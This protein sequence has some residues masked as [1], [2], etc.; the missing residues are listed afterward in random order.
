MTTPDPR[1][2]LAGRLRQA[3]TAEDA[4]HAVEII[5]GAGWRPDGPL[6]PLTAE[7]ETTAAQRDAYYRQWREAMEARRAVERHLT[8][9]RAGLRRWLDSRPVVVRVDGG[10]Y[11]SVA[12]VRAYADEQTS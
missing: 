3:L 5:V 6:P 12:S 9:T 8:A 10:D 4:E 7:L 2:D 11:L 1:A